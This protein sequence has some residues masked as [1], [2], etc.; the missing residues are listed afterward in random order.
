MNT[1]IS[2][3]RHADEVMVSHSTVQ[4]TNPF[5]YT[6]IF[7]N[8]ALHQLLSII[9]NF[10]IANFLIVPSVSIVL[11][12]KL[13]GFLYLD[14]P[15]QPSTNGYNYHKMKLIIDD[16]CSFRHRVMIHTIGSSPNIWQTTYKTQNFCD[17]L[18][19]YCLITLKN[20]YNFVSFDSVRK[21]KS[22]DKTLKQKFV[23]F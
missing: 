1:V 11:G 13:Q 9:R 17:V 15:N 18:F 3:N 5:L 12:A 2:Y 23:T 4:S 19:K 20:L 10:R 6:L 14:K 8:S 7:P 22:E 16:K 21:S